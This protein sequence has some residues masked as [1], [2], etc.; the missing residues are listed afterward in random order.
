MDKFSKNDSLG[1]HIAVLS[2]IMA[3]MLEEEL[4]KFDLKLAYW[5]TLMLLW[6]QEGQTQTDLTNGCQ[7]NHYTTTRVLDKLEVCG[8][9]ERRLDPKNRRVFRIFLT[10]KG[11]ELEAPLTQIATNINDQVLHKLEQKDQK[12]LLQLLKSVNDV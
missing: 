4:K 1:W 5:P 9:V 6:E 7:T 2:K 3:S 12:V 11:R 8:L 10:D